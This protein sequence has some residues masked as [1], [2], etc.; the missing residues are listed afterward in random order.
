MVRRM[1][2][3][4]ASCPSFVN[5]V[6]SLSSA[7]LLVRLLCPDAVQSG[8]VQYFSLLLI[9]ASLWKIRLFAVQCPRWV[10]WVG[11]IGVAVIGG[12]S[13]IQRIRAQISPPPL[14]LARFDGDPL[15]SATAR[16]SEQ[17]TYQFNR[18]QLPRAS[19][20]SLSKQAA[21]ALGWRSRS[22]AEMSAAHT[23]RGITDA[24][25]L[26]VVGGTERRLRV[27]MPPARPVPISSIAHPALAPFLPPLKLWGGG[28]SFGVSVEQFGATA[29][30]LASLVE[31][32]LTSGA[33]GENA[34]IDAGKM[35][36]LWTSIIHRAVPLLLVSERLI[37]RAVAGERVQEAFLACASRHLARA[38]SLGDFSRDRELQAA[39]YTDYGVVLWL[40][41]AFFQDKK[42]KKR[43]LALWHA[44]SSS[45]DLSAA[46]KDAAVANL[47]SV[48][49]TQA[50]PK[51]KGSGRPKK[52]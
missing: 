43:A 39:L 32:I 12:V 41:W 23:N 30:F 16:F 9:V 17:L 18:Y 8:A 48:T 35:G 46:V 51:G 50:H 6:I 27:M 45:S 28:V 3:E 26:L 14:V 20:V 10:F 31:G 4:S 40:R 44:V 7:L 1:S 2:S 38:I 52:G 42:A 5:T 47:Q 36:G 15:G 49:I 33:Q 37:T 22:A 21:D 29:E 24:R 11:L 13:I 25:P 19:W 34:L